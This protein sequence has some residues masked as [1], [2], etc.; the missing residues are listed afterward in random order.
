MTNHNLYLW[1]WW[2]IQS[3]PIT[4]PFQGRGGTRIDASRQLIGGSCAPSHLIRRGARHGEH[5]GGRRCASSGLFAPHCGAAFQPIAEADD[6]QLH[7]KMPPGRGEAPPGASWCDG[8]RNR[9]RMRLQDGGPPLPSVQTPVRAV[10]RPMARRT[11]RLC[12][13]G[14]DGFPQTGEE[15]MRCELRLLAKNHYGRS[16]Q[17]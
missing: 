15:Q 4:L 17:L 1:Q 3:L 16:N 11:E 5:Q 7:R 2:H 6:I 12:R 8:R 10:H 14:R 13:K 9:P